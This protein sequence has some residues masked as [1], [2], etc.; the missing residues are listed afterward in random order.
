MMKCHLATTS[1]SNLEPEGQKDHR[2]KIAGMERERGGGRRER[3]RRCKL[4]C[5]RKDG[6]IKLLKLGG[7]SGLNSY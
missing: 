5:K 7:Q 3:E 2:A 6:E 1:T 4:N